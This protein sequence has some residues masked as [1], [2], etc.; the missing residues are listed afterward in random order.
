V[1]LGLGFGLSLKRKEENPI[2]FTRLHKDLHT[3]YTFRDS[4]P[5]QLNYP[6][7]YV[8]NPDWI[9]DDAHTDIETV[10]TNPRKLPTRPS[11]NLGK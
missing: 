4:T 3:R 6:K 10:L 5:R 8:K 7:L 11:T 1:G 9:L 2:D